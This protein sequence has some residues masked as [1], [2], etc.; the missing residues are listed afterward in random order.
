MTLEEVC[1]QH[2]VEIEAAMA[3]LKERGL[4]ADKTALVRDLAIDLNTLP[5]DVVIYLQG[6]RTTPVE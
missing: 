4:D 5:K 3:K 6:E 1:E 2:G